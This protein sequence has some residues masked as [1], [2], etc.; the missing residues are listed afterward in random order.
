MYYVVFLTSYLVAS[1][2]G[3]CCIYHRLK[4][5]M[6]QTEVGSGCVDLQEDQRILQRKHSHKRSTR[7]P[8]ATATDSG[9]EGWSTGDDS[10][11]E[12][13]STEPS[14]SSAEGDVS[15]FTHSQS[16]T[17][18]ISLPSLIAVQETKSTPPPSADSGA[19]LGTL[20]QSPIDLSLSPSLESTTSVRG[21]CPPANSSTVSE[22]EKVSEL[23]ESN[24]PRVEDVKTKCGSEER[25]FSCGSEER[26]FSCG[27]EERDF[28]CGSE[29]RDF[30][31]GS[32]ERD[33]RE[34]S[35]GTPDQASRVEE[36]VGTPVP[37]RARLSPE[38]SS[39][40]RKLFNRNTTYSD[41]EEVQEEVKVEEKEEGEEV[42]TTSPCDHLFIDLTQEDQDETLVAP[43]M[44]DLTQD[45]LTPPPE[46][47]ITNREEEEE[48]EEE[49]AL[50]GGVGIDCTQSVVHSSQL[51]LPVALS[52]SQSSGSTSRS[53]ISSRRSASV[54]SGGLE[55]YGSPNCLPPTPGRENVYSILQRP[56]FP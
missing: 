38:Q 27:S 7:N 13:T 43:E 49:E 35:H 19:T 5:L 12:F 44:I 55:Q 29:E 3:L 16:H 52:E 23:S 30:S 50:S 26:D 9:E 32:E 42:G 28:S 48:E 20:I 36:E 41:Q 11:D 53:T 14:V 37:K 56:D 2:Y 22:T 24:S 1:W 46:P 4:E 17:S 39:V 33:F 54:E 6:P 47:N 31:C 25:D 21:V 18:P 10:I 15:V 34:E 51:S 45:H 8:T 40:S